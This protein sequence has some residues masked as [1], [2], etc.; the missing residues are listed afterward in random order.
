[1]NHVVRFVDARTGLIRT[2]AGNGKAGF[3]GDEARQ[4]RLRFMNRTVFSSIAKGIFISVTFESPNPSRQ[5]EE[6]HHYD[7]CRHR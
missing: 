1:M 3:S 2:V 5:P 4:F 7:L 6:R